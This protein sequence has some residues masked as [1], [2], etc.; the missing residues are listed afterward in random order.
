MKVGDLVMRKVNKPLHWRQASEMQMREM[1][2][3][4]IVLSKQMAGAPAHQCVTVFYPKVKK[5]YDIAESL[6]E[7]VN[8]TR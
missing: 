8:A 4:G 6:L 2:G 5:K 3:M 7:V 1:L